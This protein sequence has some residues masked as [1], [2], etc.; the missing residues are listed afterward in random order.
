VSGPASLARKEYVPPPAAV[1]RARK[2]YEAAFSAVRAAFSGVDWKD[3]PPSQRPRPRLLFAVRQC[4]RA[5]AVYAANVA[6]APKRHLAVALNSKPEEIRKLCSAVE[7]WRSAPLIED[8]LE[9]V[10][11]A[12]AVDP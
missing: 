4:E 3:A 7:T 10:K 6:G 9:R 11:H 2:R 12:A 1:E 8:L 5:L